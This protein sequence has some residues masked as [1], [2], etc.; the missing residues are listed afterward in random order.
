MARQQSR[1][2]NT[3]VRKQA[4]FWTNISDGPALWDIEHHII[5]AAGAEGNTNNDGTLTPAGDAC[6]L[7]FI[8]ANQRPYKRWDIAC[9]V[10]GDHQ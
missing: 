6:V 2:M 7:A 1:I 9:G 3:E 10:A 5:R 4:V 8:Q